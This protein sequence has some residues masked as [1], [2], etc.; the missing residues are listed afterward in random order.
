MDLSGSADKRVRYYSGGMVRRLEIGQAMFAYPKVLFLDE[1]TVGLDPVA[2]KTVWD[3]VINLQESSPFT[4]LLTTHYM[5]EAEELCS[6]VAIMNHGKLAALG[7]PQQL[8]EATGKQGATLEDA[9]RFFSQEDYD[10]R[11]SY[12]ELRRTRRI[13]K[14]LS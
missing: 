1:P 2:R 10:E 11:G 6:R 8:K 13:A 4:V 5:E 3:L 9:F 12:R 14:R 7:S